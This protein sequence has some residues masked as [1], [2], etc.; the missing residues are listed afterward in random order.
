MKHHLSFF[1][2]LISALGIRAQCTSFY[3]LQA[4]KTI[5]MSMTNARGKSTGKIIYQTGKISSI[6]GSTSSMLKQEV[7]DEKGKLIQSSENKIKCSGGV[8]MMDIKSF[9]NN[10]QDKE[11]KI[12]IKGED[13]YIEYPSALKEGTTLPDGKASFNSIRGTVITEMEMNITDRKVIAKENITT[14][15]G[16]WDCYKITYSIQIKTFVGG[17]AIPMKFNATEWFA[18]GFGVVKTASRFGETVISSI[19]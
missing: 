8:M 11:Q 3:Y 13:V 12:E 15:A 5:E 17:I 19:K 2:F 18:P 1:L 10:S 16:T 4:N 7:F 9:M 6:G 14:A